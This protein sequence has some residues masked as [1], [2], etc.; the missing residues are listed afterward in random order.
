MS[1]CRRVEAILAAWEEEGALAGADLRLVR[2]HCSACTSC[3]SRFSALLPL[4]TRDTA[5][6]MV[7]GLPAAGLADRVMERVRFSSPRRLVP[8]PAWAAVAAALLVA[9]GLSLAALARTWTSPQ[10]DEVVV[11]F[12]LDAPG[13]SSV[14]L[15]GTFNDWDSSR[16]MMAD[17]GH[18]GVWQV[19]VRLKKNSLAVYNFVIDGSRWV[20][21]PRSPAQ[22]DDG[23][24]GH[25]SVMKL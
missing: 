1:D 20:V 2:A 17:P 3:S 9:A 19:S 22:V 10:P 12:E 18:D 15:V 25:S 24:G 6:V 23:F 7:R 16:L 5:E 8:G 4:L 13:A 14:A 11:R 21:D